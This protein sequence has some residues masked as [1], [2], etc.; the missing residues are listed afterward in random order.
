MPPTP[1]AGYPPAGGYPNAAETPGYS[2]T[3]PP[4]PPGG[5]AAPI[6]GVRPAGRGPLNDFLEGLG[7]QA[8]MVGI[9]SAGLGL[10][11]VVCCVCTSFGG[12]G[13]YF[14]TLILAIPAVGLG[15][16][17]L[18]K[19]KAGQATNQNLAFL[20][21]ALGVLGLIIAICGGTTHVGTDLHNDVR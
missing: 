15:I 14:F 4:P 13:A 9:L 16:L 1:P 20:G 11:S 8:N 7:G 10:L 12:G 18:R 5:R 6:P 19:V 2:P 21:I 17:H 3:A